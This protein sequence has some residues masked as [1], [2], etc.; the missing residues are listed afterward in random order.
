MRLLIFLTSKFYI[1]LDLGQLIKREIAARSILFAHWDAEEYGLIGSTEFAEE[2]RTQLMRRAVA[3][4]NM[5]LI[6]GNQTL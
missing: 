4:I 5:D 2:Y 3:V 6:G 1:F